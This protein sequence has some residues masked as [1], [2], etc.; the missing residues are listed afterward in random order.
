VLSD[1]L[2]ISMLV[3]WI[4][5]GCFAFSVFTSVPVTFIEEL[6]VSLQISLK[7]DNLSVKTI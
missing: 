7:F 5:K 3:A 2:S 4:S 1:K 6:I